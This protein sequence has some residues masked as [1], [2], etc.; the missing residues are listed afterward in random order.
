M[1]HQKYV[2]VD[3]DGTIA[4]YKGWVS[5][6]HFGEPITGVHEALE[7]IRSG[8]W[9]IIIHTTRGNRTLIREYLEKHTI[10]F[11]YINENPDQPPG[12]SDGKPIAEA[13]VDD[14]GIQFN[15]DWAVTVEEILKF[16]PWENRPEGKS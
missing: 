13:Y 4:H 7:K 15:G 11:D 1:S 8:G 10:P 16:I 2:C 14:R 6:T 12:A 5:E 9:K 3:L